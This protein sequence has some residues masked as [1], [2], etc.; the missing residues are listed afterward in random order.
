MWRPAVVRTHVKG[1]S[2]KSFTACVDNDEEFIERFTSQDEGKEWRRMMPRR[3]EMVEVEVE[4]DGETE[5]RRAE[6]VKRLFASGEF[7]A[8]VSFPDGSPD[9]D[10]VETFR[11]ESEG[12]EWRRIKRI[13]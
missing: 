13:A 12:S 8:M 3:S 6:V 11:L 10:F 4:D 9:Y 7:T 1:A 2:P 5:W